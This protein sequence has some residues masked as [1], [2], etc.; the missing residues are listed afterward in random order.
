MRIRLPRLAG[1]Q[2]PEKVIAVALLIAVF[3]EFSGVPV[4]GARK[5][6]SRPFPCQNRPCGC[7]SADE[8]WHHCCCF[9]NKQKVAWCRENGVTP[10]DFVVA[11]AAH[12]GEP[13]EQLCEHRKDCCATADAPAEE[14]ACCRHRK[15]Q[16]DSP[17]EKSNP[18]DTVKP[19]T[20][21]VRLVLSDLARQCRGLPQLISLLCDALPF[22]DRAQYKPSLVAIGSVLERPASCTCPDLAPPVPPPKLADALA[23]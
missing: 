13:T 8:C 17:A 20:T 9:T 14:H 5:D 10:P 6:R 22:V 19:S 15:G 2:L 4:G 23:A 21:K 16:A 12:E 18:E 7:A 11:A 3:G 1:R